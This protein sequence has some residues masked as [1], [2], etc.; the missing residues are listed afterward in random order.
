MDKLLE[1]YKA[2]ER[3]L[4]IQVD[5]LFSMDIPPVEY[6]VQSFLPKRGR[7]LISAATNLGKSFLAMNLSYLV[8]SGQEKF[9]GK[10]DV[11]P[12]RVLYLDLEMGISPVKERF[13][14]IIPEDA[15]GLPIFYLDLVGQELFTE[16]NSKLLEDAIKTNNIDVVVIDT[17]GSAWLGD[18]NDEQEVT[19]FTKYLDSLIVDHKIS[20]LLVHHWRKATQHNK[21]GGEMAA[22][23]HRWT[24]W[25]ENHVTLS[26][27]D[28]NLVLTSEKSR[29][30]AKFQPMRIKL[31]TETLKFEYVGDFEKKFTEES[32]MDVFKSFGDV[33]EVPMP[34]VI[35]R[36][37]EMNLGSA[38][39]IRDLAKVSDHYK[40]DTT[41]KTHYL[42]SMNG[43]KSNLFDCGNRGS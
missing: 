29:Y 4:P 40:L 11:S 15:Q 16:E 22:G 41:R 27:K 13:R 25:V 20:L 28:S 21:T 6:Y 1:Q 8:A 42:C 30:E 2:E 12:A 3:F 34:S 38:K 24:A 14:K 35:Q 33:T 23:S 36:A 43:H 32:L 17:I 9:L 39:V 5:A 19:R 26:G 18:K 37:K 10:F 31:D 7:A